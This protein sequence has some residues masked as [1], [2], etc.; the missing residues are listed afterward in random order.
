MNNFSFCENCD[1]Q[2][3]SAIGVKSVAII[4]SKK[5]HRNSVTA[6]RRGVALVFTPSLARCPPSALPVSGSVLQSQAI[7]PQLQHC[8][9][10]PTRQLLKRKWNFCLCISLLIPRIKSGMAETNLLIGVVLLMM[11]ANHAN[12]QG[13]VSFMYYFKLCGK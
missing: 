10:K 4:F 2:P 3:S 13:T 11:T 5:K 8:C 9:L 6:H 7:G 1:A 12:A